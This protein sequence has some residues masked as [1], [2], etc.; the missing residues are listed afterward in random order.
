[1]QGE[2]N[3]MSMRPNVLLLDDDEAVVVALG[4]LLQAE[5]YDVHS[6]TSAFEFLRDHDPEVP[7]CLI[8]DLIMPEMSGL[9][10][11][12]EL[13][14]QGWP[15][16]IVFITGKGKMPMMVQAMKAGAVTFLA[17]PVDATDLL[18]AVR[19]ATELD[20]RLRAYRRERCAVE[21]RV[22]RLTPRERE[23]LQLVA[24]GWMN[25]QIAAELGASEK[26]VKVHRGRVMEK[27][28]VRSA[29]ELVGLLSRLDIE[30]SDR[31]RFVAPPYAP[32]ARGRASYPVAAR[33]WDE[34]WH[35]PP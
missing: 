8:S 6:W 4:R 31:R 14:Q 19:E 11:Q 9:E 20:A 18:M 33:Q 12:H 1:V 17:K 15:R 30:V 21:Q 16:P 23:V 5:G 24:A 7:G 13:L 2:Q 35:D 32:A 34:D 22:E 25:K 26:T 3:I 27:M 10:L 29:A 28:Q